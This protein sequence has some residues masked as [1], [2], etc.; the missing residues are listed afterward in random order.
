ML[1]PRSTLT[2]RIVAALDAS[3]REVREHALTA[4]LNRPCQTAELLL[5]RRWPELRIE[6]RE[7]QR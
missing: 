5:L 7:A 3:Q 1:T 6:G 4:I 2:R